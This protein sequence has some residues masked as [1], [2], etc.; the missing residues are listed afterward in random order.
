MLIG[1]TGKARSGKD[2]IAKHLATKHGFSHYWLSKPMKDALAVMLGWTSEHLYGDLKEVVDNTYGVS[3]RYALQ[4]IGTE[5]G[6]ELINQD[7]WLILAEQQIRRNPNL[8]ISDIRFDNEAQL[9]RR[10][11]GIVLKITRV[12]ADEV[13]DHQS[14]AGV[15]DHF[16]DMSVTNDGSIKELQDIIDFIFFGGI[17]D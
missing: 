16:I 13:Q 4:T 11:G 15:S 3:P 5:W 10:M 2:T 6:R 9:I 7:L 14:E 12:D 8:V 1:I 17:D